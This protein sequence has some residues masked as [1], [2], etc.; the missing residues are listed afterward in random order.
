MGVSPGAHQADPEDGPPRAQT[1]HVTERA[2]APQG[3]RTARFRR[4]ALSPETLQ[5]IQSAESALLGHGRL[6]QGSGCSSSYC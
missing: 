6:G 4:H 2:G 3:L 5:G 1:V